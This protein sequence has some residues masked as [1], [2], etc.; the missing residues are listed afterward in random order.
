MRITTDIHGLERVAAPGTV[1]RGFPAQ[2]RPGRWGR[3]FRLLKAALSSDY[4]VINFSLYEVTFFSVFLFLIPFHQCRLVTLD[5][6]V[7]NPKPWQRPLV[8]WALGRIH[9]L[10]VYFRDNARFQAR[11]GIPPDKFQYIPFKI[12]SW[13]L[14][15]AATIS[16]EGYIF[17]GGRS[18]R[19]FR[20]LFEAVRSLPCPVK[21]LTASEADINPHGSTLAGLQPP[22]NVEIL[23]NDSDPQVFVRLIA[24]SRFVALPILKESGIQ[25]GIGVYLLSM[26]LRKCVII[27]EALGVSDV[28][29][30]GQAC[31]IRPGDPQ[32]LHDAIDTLWQDDALRQQ[33]A[34]AGYRYAT[35]LGGEDALRLSILRAIEEETRNSEQPVG[36]GAFLLPIWTKRL[37]HRNRVDVPDTPGIG[38]GL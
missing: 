37:F 11:W 10:L 26:A 24:N 17:V 2:T 5:F 14:V 27:S 38:T 9:K 4:L 15:Q 6:F 36:E 33:Y 30:D 7:V 35:P 31:I 32:A 1:I 8:R 34:E 25:A 18:R 19:D 13:E 23:Y 22:P 21:L 3:N 29:L 16:D 12:N 28:L 20:T